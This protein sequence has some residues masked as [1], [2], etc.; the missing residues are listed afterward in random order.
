MIAACL[1]KI[2][3]KTGCW[4]GAKLLMEMYFMEIHFICDCNLVYVCQEDMVIG[5]WFMF[6]DRTIRVED[7]QGS[8]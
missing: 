5:F 8:L 3:L 2:T 7:I 1:S 4:G 6:I